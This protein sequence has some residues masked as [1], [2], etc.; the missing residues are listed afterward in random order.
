MVD[1]ENMD[2]PERIRKEGMRRMYSY[3]TIQAYQDHVRRFLENIQKP[4]K[5]ISKKDI[6][7]YLENMAER[8]KAGSTLNIHLNALK[9]FFWACLGKRINVDLK[10]SKIPNKL[11]VV[12]SKE[13]VR[14][15]FDAIKN[16][17]HKFMIAFM[18]STGVR[19]SELTNIHIGDLELERNFGW[20]RHGKGDKDR[21][22]VV[23]EK[24]REGLLKMTE[25]KKP[26]DFLFVTN[27]NQK[28]DVQS[29]YKI[30]KNAS[31]N[32]GISRYKNV[33]PHTLRHSFAT[34]LIENGYSIGDVQHLLGHASPETTTVYIHTA[35]SKML[36]I[37][38][39]LD[40]L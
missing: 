9:F 24:L 20:V 6:R 31:R 10:Y 17:K 22:F 23:S 37:K 1:I 11:P 12:L 18:Y 38:S 3:R 39:P 32:S 5:E 13:E 28:Y 4:L 15:L 27:K 26:E 7:E 2:I 19:V 14:K 33:H 34:H 25:N 29:V 8:G 16:E 21:M 36:G 40:E 35:S 30:I